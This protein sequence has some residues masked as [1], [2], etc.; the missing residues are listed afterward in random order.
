M[1]NKDILKKIRQEAKKI[2]PNLSVF[3]HER[4]SDSP[5]KKKRSLLALLSSATLVL[6][7]LVLGLLLGNFSSISISSSIQTSSS[8]STSSP[9]ITPSQPPIS[10]VSLPPLRLEGDKAALS[11]STIA[12]ASLFTNLTNANPLQTK[13]SLAFSPNRP[14][15]DFNE[16][17]NLLQPYLGMFEQL[18]GR[19]EAP[20]IVTETLD[21][22]AFAYVDRF[23]VVDIQ[24]TSVS[25]ELFYNLENVI[26]INEELFYDL[27]GELKINGGQPFNVLGR[28]VLDDD[29]KI[30]SFKAELDATNYIESLYTFEEDETKISIKKMTDGILN[31]SI[32]KLEIDEDETEIELLFLQENDERRIRD[33]FKFEYEIEENETILKISFSVMTEVGIERGKIKVRVVEV[34]DSNNVVI[35]YEYLAYNL[36]END[37][38]KDEWRDRRDHRNNDE[39]EDEDEEENEDDEDEDD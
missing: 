14:T 25:Y 34:L 37:E 3:L 32:F 5:A 17:M 9:S 31:I 18:L 6:S 19:S 15:F 7:V 24:G 12:T 27:S 35:G 30:L 23:S 33:R 36:D 21:E 4:F 20:T 10:E 2:E 13:R 28:K 1:N 22:G 38:E 39:D 8:T 11:I 29:E 16:T 26:D